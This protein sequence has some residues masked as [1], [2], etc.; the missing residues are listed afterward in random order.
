VDPSGLINPEGLA[1]SPDGRHLVTV[2]LQYSHLPDDY[3]RVRPPTTSSITLLRFN[4]STG[5][6]EVVD[7]HTFDG[8]LPQGVVFDRTG[9]H[10][11]HAV[12]DFHGAKSERGAVRF[13]KL[14]RD[15]EPRLEPLPAE[16]ST[17]RGTHSLT[18]LP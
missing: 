16:I 5:E 10:V 4:R 11:A 1:I 13:W 12:F 15:G 18:V 6:T 8:I 7:E 3:D 17:V 14:H 9:T 2:N